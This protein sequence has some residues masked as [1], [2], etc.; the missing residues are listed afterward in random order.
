[1]DYRTGRSPSRSRRF[2]AGPS[3]LQPLRRAPRLSEHVDKQYLDSLPVA[4]AV[5]REFELAAHEDPVMLRAIGA[6][7]QGNWS[8]TARRASADVLDSV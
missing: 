4:H 6:E 7:R 8:R 1:M 2:G 3:P 5:D